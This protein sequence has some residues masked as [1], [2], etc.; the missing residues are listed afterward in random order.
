MVKF[1]SLVN[2]AP[3]QKKKAEKVSFQTTVDY[4]EKRHVFSDIADSEKAGVPEAFMD[5]NDRV[6]ERRKIQFRKA[7]D[8]LNDLFL[9][10]KARKK[11]SISGGYKIIDELVNLGPTTDPLFI[12]SMRENKAYED[13]VIHCVNVCTFAIR[14]GEYLGYTPKKQTELGFAALLQDLGMMIIS[15]DILNKDGKLTDAEFMELKRHPDYSYKL[16]LPFRETYPFLPDVARQIHERLDG[17]GY[18]LH[19]KGEEIHEYAQIIGIMDTYDALISSRSHR[20][21][22]LHF[23]AVKEIIKSSKTRFQRRHLKALLSVF[24]IFPL[25]SYVKLNS[26][27]ICRV[28]ETNP[29]LP[30][31]PKLQIITDSQGKRMY[32]D[33]IL[34]LPDNPILYIVDSFAEDDLQAILNEEQ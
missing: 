3:V 8:F 32:S 27:A 20:E 18:P 16:F 5:G 24:S 9:T 23:S 30:M 13:R 29:E 31:R 15:D 12:K 6:E 2:N 7:A 25:Y 28:I 1:T 34:N 26:N 22:F 17:S 21:K 10:V 11:F 19:L 4:E 33:H 14:M